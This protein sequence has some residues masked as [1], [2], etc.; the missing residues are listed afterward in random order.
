MLIS[1]YPDLQSDDGIHEM[2]WDPVFASELKPRPQEA[3]AVFR[4]QQPT[5][6]LLSMARVC[7]SKPV[8][9]GKV[10]LSLFFKKDFY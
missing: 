9:V 1:A 7:P 10:Y 2:R 3:W 6:D 8:T 4:Y 5:P